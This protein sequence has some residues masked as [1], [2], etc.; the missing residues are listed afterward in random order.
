MHC[1]GHG[2][3]PSILVP[4]TPGYLNTLEDLLKHLGHQLHPYLPALLAL[5]LC[6][7][8]GGV[9]PLLEGGDGGDGAPV[10]REAAEGGREV[11]A[12]CL[13]LLAGVLERFPAAADYNFLWPRLTAAAEP[14]LLRLAAEA[15]A[16]RPPPLLALAVALAS[17]QHL[18]GVLADGCSSGPEQL[19]PPARG[20][21][22]ASAADASAGAGAGEPRPPVPPAEVLPCA[23]LWAA[24]RQLGSRLLTA[25]VAMLA[26]PACAEPSRLAMLAALES[27]FD[28]PDPLPQQLLGPHMSALLSGLQAVVVSV[29]QASQQRG[30]AG[31]GLLARRAGGAAVR[32]AP[33]RA[34]AARALAILELVGARVGSWEAAEQLTAALLPL[35]APA[36]RGR[37]GRR[38]GGAGAEEMVGRTL[39]VLA[40][41]WT[42][43]AS[44]NA[45]QPPPPQQQQQQREEQLRR[46]AAA[47]APLTGSLEGF[48]AR[49]AL[50]AAMRALG[51]VLPETAGTAQLLVRL[52]AMD[53]TTVDELDYEARL[54]AYVSLR[55]PAWAAMTAL[56]A[57]PL[58]HQASGGAACA[59]PW[60]WGGMRAWL[61]TRVA[62]VRALLLN[63]L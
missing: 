38:R 37:G 25:C 3:T 61:L 22:E 36:E 16:D 51:A 2:L 62:S 28:L 42:R 14:L 6:L 4:P 15:A 63:H 39:A 1:H 11:R 21:A 40:A 57:A 54:A 27:I 58:L 26:A 5:A 7:L 24:K 56:Q 60:S 43:L 9:A 19:L 31:G 47:L 55:P 46:V 17:S 44:N 48:E 59:R 8:E 34:T 45:E 49:Q 35:L 29:W 30:G 12:R 18:A 10:E 41:L 33:R 20:D 23:E 52:N 53:S 13:R 32:A 50:A